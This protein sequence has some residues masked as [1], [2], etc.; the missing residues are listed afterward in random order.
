[1]AGPWCTAVRGHT[2]ESAITE[3]VAEHYRAVRAPRAPAVIQRIADDLNRSAGPRD[4]LQLT[5]GEKCDRFTVRRPERIGRALRALE[6]DGVERVERPHPQC[7]SRNH[8]HVASVRRQLKRAPR[9]SAAADPS[10][11]QDIWKRA[12]SAGTTA[13]SVK[14]CTL[15]AT[16]ASRP[17]TA[18]IQGR[19]DARPAR[20]AAG[21]VA[22][23][24]STRSHTSLMSR[25][26]FFGSFSRHRAIR[27]RRAGRRCAKI[28]RILHD[29]RERFGD[30]LTS[31][32]PAGRN[33]F[34]EDAAERP[35]VGASST[36][37]PLACSGDMYAAVPSSTPACVMAG[38]VSIGECDRIAVRAACR[39]QRLGQAEVE[40]LDDAVGRD[41][42]VGRLEIAVDDAAL[43]R[44]LERLG[45]LPRDGQR[46]V[47]RQRPTR[48][49]IGER[50]RPRPAPS[51]A[52]GRRS[53]VLEAVDARC[54]DGSARR[55]VV[56]SRSNRASRSASLAKA[57]GRILIATSRPSFVSRARYT[58]PMP[59]APMVRRFRRA[60]D[61]IRLKRHRER[62]QYM[63]GDDR[64]CAHSEQSPPFLFV[65]K[66]ERRAR[67]A[68]RAAQSYGVPEESR[69]M[70]AVTSAAAF[71]SPCRQT[72]D[73][74]SAPACRRD[75]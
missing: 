36:A 33:H 22:D 65:T 27:C 44:R 60:R 64:D 59:P 5:A 52:R 46:L 30:V 35:D 8:Q 69:S 71:C 32:G 39:V 31:E 54:S 73:S 56:A 57:S 12:V 63:A 7:A 38:D 48:D 51:R 1:M 37:R 34:I 61:A 6:A 43:V 16:A 42:H 58:S 20:G 41:L 62:C 40:H 10:V 13:F 18:A 17:A 45:D 74:C 4:P 66:K 72:A 68:R 23:Y 70:I 29:R 55:G 75:P 19:L 21:P 67:K 25:I 14:S 15:T 2:V 28:W 53:P 11:G 26:R 9:M 49:A 24:S 50:R 47:E 3:P